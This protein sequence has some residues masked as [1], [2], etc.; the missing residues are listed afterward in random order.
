MRARI[1]QLEQQ[2]KKRDAQPQSAAAAATAGSTSMHAALLPSS[3]AAQEPQQTRAKASEP[4]ASQ[5]ETGPSEP[6][7]YADWTWLNGN[8]RTKHPVFDSKFF[9][10]EIRF[11]TNFIHSFNHPQDDTM[12]GSTEM[13]RS[14]E[15]QIE[16][17]S[18]GGDF[19]WEN[20][21]GRILTMNG[22]FG[23]TTPRSNMRRHPPR[24]TPLPAGRAPASN[25][26]LT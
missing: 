13:F 5:Q 12:G 4:A 14:N 15:I 3:T 9:T 21:R 18:F 26:R 23:V 1:Q 7:A 17:I 19:H 11:D 8:A 6:F 16:Q 20:V 25:R 24:T 22:M 10:P 2:L